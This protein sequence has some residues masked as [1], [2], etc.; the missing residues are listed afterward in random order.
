ME[1]L[2]HL[3]CPLC[4]CHDLRNYLFLHSNVIRHLSLYG[5][6]N[7]LLLEVSN[8]FLCNMKKLGPKLYTSYALAVLQWPRR[9][10]G[11]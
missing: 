5:F 9:A 6:V 1:C 7:M 2:S 8:N 4:L 3:C 10:I 11:R